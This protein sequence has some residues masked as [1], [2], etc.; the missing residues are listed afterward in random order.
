[1]KRRRLRLN[2]Y[3]FRGLADCKLGIQAGAIARC[4]G[5]GRNSESLEVRRFDMNF[6]PADRQRE[7]TL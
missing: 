5:Q 2:R 6:V 4:E 3:A 7:I 1:M